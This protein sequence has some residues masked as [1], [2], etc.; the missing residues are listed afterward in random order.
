MKKV[1]SAIF[2]AITIVL[3]IS[4]LSSAIS[5]LGY[6]R[7]IY[8]I[9]NI[10]TNK[11]NQD[12][13]NQ[14]NHLAL[15]R[16]IMLSEAV[17]A[18]SI[19]KDD[20]ITETGKKIAAVANELKD[21]DISPEDKQTVQSI[22]DVNNK[23]SDTYINLISP[24]I[25]A[26]EGK[27]TG[28]LSQN[29][30]GVMTELLNS[31]SAII[32][33]QQ[34]QL[35]VRLDNALDDIIDLNKKVQLIYTDAQYMSNE[36]VQ[37]KNLLADILLRF[38][39]E[40]TT[41]G[42]PADGQ[43]SDVLSREIAELEQKI[44]SVSGSAQM[45]L[46]NSAHV[47]DFDRVFNMKMIASDWQSYIKLNEL[48]S[49]LYDSNSLLMST[50]AT[51]V[52]TQA[53]FDSNNTRIDQVVSALGEDA[54]FKEKMQSV[55]SQYGQYKELAVQIYKR[56]EGMNTIHTEY[57]SLIQLDQQYSEALA[58]LQK[59]FDSYFSDDV[60]NSEA[61]KRA[62]FWIFIGTTLLSLLFGMII[63][64]L[65]SRRITRPIKSLNE[66]LSKVEKG[67]LTAR[68]DLSDSNDLGD[69]LK[70]VNSVLDGQQ[71]MVEQF[72][73]SS[74]EITNLK[75]KLMLLVKQNRESINKLSGTNFNSS[76]EKV[77]F[78][79][80]EI[81]TDVKSVT[82]QTQKAVGDSIRAVELAKSREKT[83]EE[84]E[85]V[86]NTVNETVKSIASSIAKL[87]AS[88]GKIGEITNTITQIASQTNLLALNAAIEANRAG[89]QGKGFAVVADEIRK[90]SNASNQSAGEIKAQI[91]EIQESINFAV[92]KMNIGVIGVE[93]GAARINEVKE[94]IAEIID[95]V[96]QVAD[97]IKAS[98][99]TAYNH[100]NS[101]VHF[102]EAV[103]SRTK[104]SGHIASTGGNTDT[105]I[106]MQVDTLNNIENITR[107]LHE[108]S[109]DLMNLSE[110]VKI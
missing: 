77:S 54:S 89:Q 75:Q 87:E 45:V 78:G 55:P 34:S 49:L 13:L 10:Q 1:K 35:Q 58:R 32:T 60:K 20:S 16:H 28:E 7:V 85:E 29:A 61:I 96:N 103:D 93:D 63:A 37:I 97:T 104:D 64:L 68:A 70:Q 5:F 46:D 99:D 42:E 100:Y 67:D 94:G 17:N 98:A 52:N 38:Q 110:R 88:S 25:S 82:E 92:E 106:Q 40:S 53:E 6:T 108:A 86:I 72:R 105:V 41:S 11:S 71:K 90:L 74:K 31:L 3:V 47:E 48:L 76:P 18:F 91:R 51:S 66:I 44:S 50:A 19:E 39:E 69:V 102:I 65:L 81:L 95:S 8:S 73:D 12:K 101:T 14:L 33:E 24:A 80:E 4:L 56:V 57:S 22:I 107:L 43:Q 30:Q 83:V 109:D 36:F 59:S 27:G 62:I 9:N 23:Y 79:T 26:F 21:A 15:S 84:A 2:G